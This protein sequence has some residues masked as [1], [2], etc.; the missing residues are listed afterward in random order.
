MKDDRLQKL[1]RDKSSTEITNLSRN[2]LAI[3]V[4][5]IIFYVLLVVPV[6]TEDWST[7]VVLTIIFGA[8]FV[9]FFDFWWEVNKEVK[10]RPILEAKRMREEEERRKE[11]EEFERAQKE[12]GLVKFISHA[13]QEKWG[14]RLEVARW[15]EIEVGLSNNFAEYSPFEFEEFIG[16]LFQKMGYIV[17]VTQKTAD[18]GVDVV[19]RKGDEA[20]AIQ[21]KQYAHGNNV[22]AKDVQQILGAMWRFKA[23]QSI[24]ITTSG[25]TIRAREQAKEAPVE[26]WDKRTLHEMV[27]KYFIDID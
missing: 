7:S 22:G 18:Y 19:A 25:F 15:R 14:T 16:R 6:F 1:L 24:I 17:D 5:I 26:L 4:I 27:R 9:F 11:E 21:V 12:K 2:V 3:L 20:I 23:N 13:G 10:L 8:V